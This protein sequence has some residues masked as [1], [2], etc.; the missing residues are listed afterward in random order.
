VHLEAA[1]EAQLKISSR[2]LNIARLVR[3]GAEV[4]K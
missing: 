3:L 4:K 1:Q 2:L